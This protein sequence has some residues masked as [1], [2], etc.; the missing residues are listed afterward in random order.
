MGAEGDAAV[1]GAGAVAH[2]AVDAA[3]PVTAAEKMTV[4]AANGASRVDGG[5]DCG[6]GAADCRAS[7]PD[8][9]SWDGWD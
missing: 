8:A 1:G 7:S 2:P 5:E 6:E 9:S 4:V 3:P